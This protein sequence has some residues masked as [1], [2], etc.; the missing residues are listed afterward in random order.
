MFDRILALKKG[1]PCYI[2]FQKKREKIIT[3]KRK[4]KMALAHP[5]PKRLPDL[6]CPLVPAT[7]HAHKCCNHV[8]ISIICLKCDFFSIKKLN[9]IK[10]NDK[11]LSSVLFICFYLAHGRRKTPQKSNLVPFNM[12]C[13]MHYL[14]GSKEI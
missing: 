8:Q 2:L 11:K 1:F 14:I 9:P 5:L 3:K 13:C 4:T 6:Y 12:S 7:Y 10:Q